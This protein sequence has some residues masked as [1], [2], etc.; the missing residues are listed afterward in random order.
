MEDKI[1]ADSN[2]WLYAFMDNG[3]KKSAAAAIIVN[4]KCIL[5]TQIV[6]EVCVN[7]IKKADYGEEDISKLVE[8]LY[9]NYKIEII[10][11][12]VILKSSAIRKSMS[13][14]YWDSLVISSA[15]ESG[16]KIL[17]SEDNQII[18]GKLKI[19]NPFKLKE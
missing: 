17:Y 7:L 15:L 10:N 5:S 8:N 9:S 13:V 19:I 14:S 1:F 11:K 16:C 6:N 12:A 18:E 3:E 2:I 4:N